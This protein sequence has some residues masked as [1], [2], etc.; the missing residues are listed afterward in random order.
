MSVHVR[1]QYRTASIGSSRK[2]TN[3]RRALIGK[4]RYVD[5]IFLPEMVYVSFV[6]SSYA[7]AKIKNLNL[8]NCE[9]TPNIIETMTGSE[10]KDCLSPDHGEP[11]FMY[12]Y[13]PADKTLFVGEPLGAVVSDKKLYLEDA[14]ESARIDYEPLTPLVD[15]L[16][17]PG[18]KAPALHDELKPKNT[19]LH[20]KVESENFPSVFGSA[21]RVVTRR[22]SM[23]RHSPVPMETR[24]CLA[25]YDPSYDR[26]TVWSGTQMPHRFRGNLSN[27]LGI[28]ESRIRV[29]N[30]DVGGSFGSRVIYPEE[31]CTAV[32]AMKLR[33]PVKWIEDRK[34]NLLS[35]GQAREQIHDV[36]VALDSDNKLLAIKDVITANNG[37]YL[38]TMRLGPVESTQS[39]MPL[40]YNLKAASVEINCVA[41]NK[42]PYGA[43][44]GYG[45]PSAV[46]VTERMVDIIAK[47]I[48]KDPLDFRAANLVTDFPFVT[49]T[50][51]YYDSGSFV[52]T[53]D[54]ARQIS[55]YL[56]FRRR[57][58]ELRTQGRFLGIGFAHHVSGS[59]S[60]NSYIS[61]WPGYETCIVTLDPSGGATV[62]TGLSN[63]GQGIETLLA[64]VVSQELSIPEESIVVKSG[65]TEVIPFGLGTWGN[66]ASVVGVSSAAMAARQMSKR[67][68]VIAAKLLDCSEDE[69]AQ[70]ND[71]Y[72]STSSGTRLTLKEL[73]WSAYN[74]YT[75]MPPGFTLP[76]L[77]VAC[78]FPPN[79][80]PHNKYA[81][82]SNGVQAA[83]VE[84]DVETGRVQVLKYFGAV[85]CGNMINPGFVNSQLFGGMAQGIGGTLY[86]E[87]KF[88]ENGNP[89]AVSFMDYLLPTSL[90]IPDA[91]FVHLN[92][93][94]PS[95][96]LGS[97]GVSEDGIVG[98]YAAV[99]NAIEDA[100]GMTEI[101]HEVCVTP[102]SIWKSIVKSQSQ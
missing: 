83:I 3:A 74:D 68:R 42:P 33:R 44:R 37:A 71:G 88:D 26:L 8:G 32:L 48:K 14:L 73:C 91:E 45:K 20:K 96:I 78:A 90:E 1:Q 47:E 70:N 61:K 15:A 102:E 51:A 40:G 34:E 55:G 101:V 82:Y 54:K 86:E 87:S 13:L 53:L 93:P 66:R 6:R 57:Q 99:T 62:L 35:S 95:T 89:L 18:A 28:Q 97:K 12:F 75:R 98:P 41:T 36:S 52:E 56:E 21:A 22:L 80:G 5:D 77:E 39:L 31:I 94:S 69:L 25:D 72:Y 49:S 46:F 92:T 29:I 11:G 16:Q 84:V 24:G 27:L 30:P 100:L 9:N 17:S 43:F 7:H 38:M 50:G 58:K 65:D 67:L 4:N 2:S 19:Y 59:S 10:F 79:I 81:T 23:R 60:D 63:Q 76:L 64:Q 85:D